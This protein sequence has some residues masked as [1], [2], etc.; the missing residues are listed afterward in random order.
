MRVW[1]LGSGS[2]GNALVV[3]CAGHR[4]LIDCGFGPRA[5][6]KRLHAVNIA[7]ESI[8][9]LLVT[10]EHVDHAQGVTRA[11]HKWRWPVVATGG[12]IDAIGE[13]PAR[14]R[15]EIVPG[16]PLALDGFTVDA[17]AIPH[18]AAAPAAFRLT[19]RASGERVGI[20][21]DLGRVPASVHDA[22]CGLEILCVEANH[23]RDLLRSGRYPPRLQE[24]IAGGRGHLSNVETLAWLRETARATTREVVLLHLSAENNTPAIAER[25]LRDGLKATVFRGSVRAAPRST[26]TPIAGFNTPTGRSVQL[27]LGI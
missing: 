17:Y 22:F 12:T 8:E 20:A 6:A 21:H 26:P 11:Q 2:S 10:H 19:S 9:A 4:V 14:W 25:T 27:G 16:T 24:R 13:I 18:D 7:P 1:S 3:E 23:D 5:I 15:R